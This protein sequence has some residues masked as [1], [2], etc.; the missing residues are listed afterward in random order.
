MINPKFIPLVMA[1]ESLI[2]AIVYA[3]VGDLR[4]ACYWLCACGITL[5]IT[6]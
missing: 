4:R 5:S 6:L 3:F 1:G 2:A